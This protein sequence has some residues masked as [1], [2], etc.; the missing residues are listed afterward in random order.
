MKKAREL[1]KYLRE[2]KAKAVT[3]IHTS[4]ACSIKG[5]TL[6]C[7]EWVSRARS[8]QNDGTLQGLVGHGKGAKFYHKGFEQNSNMV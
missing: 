7:L 8:S 2:H 3:F 1:L 6:V 4:L 5:K